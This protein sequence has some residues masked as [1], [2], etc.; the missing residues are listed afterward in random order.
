MGDGQREGWGRQGETG[1]EAGGDRGLG[2]SVLSQLPVLSSSRADGHSSGQEATMSTRGRVRGSPEVAVLQEGEGFVL[3][4]LGGQCPWPCACQVP[5]NSQSGTRCLGSTA[6]PV[7]PGRSAAVWGRGGCPWPGPGHVCPSARSLE[8]PQ[9][10]QE[11][12][13]WPLPL[14]R[15]GHSLG[16]RA[17]PKPWQTRPPRDTCG[18]G[19]PQS[20]RPPWLAGRG[21]V[22]VPP[23]A[24][25]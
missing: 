24:G 14:S 1:R 13:L 6:L 19:D 25:G 5:T 12:D 15:P 20:P 11:R 9:C 22:G 8:V 2:F 10:D 3:G 23:S 18:D 4:A 17:A 21:G 7:L 16:L